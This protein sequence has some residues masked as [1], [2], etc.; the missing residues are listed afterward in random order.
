M[1]NTEILREEPIFKAE[2]KMTDIE[3][4]EL[5]KFMLSNTHG[6]LIWL[7]ILLLAEIF[8]I[9][10]GIAVKGSSP[11]GFAFIFIAVIIPV[12]QAIPM[13]KR[14]KRNRDN[15]IGNNYVYS[16]YSSFFVVNFKG[17]E[18]PLNYINCTAYETD[19][20]FYIVFKSEAFV[21]DKESFEIGTAEDFAEY[22]KEKLGEKFK[23]CK[24]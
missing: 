17:N 11:L 3:H 13:F 8:F 22:L 23:A 15:I 2:F 20:K 7:I 5:Q 1:E 19:K 18:T 9:R 4:K 12:Y 24:K 6:W 14:L 21:I 16:F 10:L